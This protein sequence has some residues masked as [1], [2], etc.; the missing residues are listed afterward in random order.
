[1]ETVYAHRVNTVLISGSVYT[2][3]VNKVRTEVKSLFPNTPHPIFLF[4][5]LRPMLDSEGAKAKAG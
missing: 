2:H 3:Y 1:L 5:L 4:L